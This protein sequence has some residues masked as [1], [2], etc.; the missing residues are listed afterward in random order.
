MKAPVCHASAVSATVVKAPVLSAYV[1]RVGTGTVPVSEIKPHP[2]LFDFWTFSKGNNADE[3]RD[4]IVGLNNHVLRAYNFLWSPLSGYGHPDYPGA[5]VLDGMD[6][7]L[8]L[9]DAYFPE[10]DYTVITKVLPFEGQEYNR[11][12]CIRS[13][14]NPRVDYN[15]LSYEFNNSQ[16][17][18]NYANGGFTGR[19]GGSI[20]GEADVLAVVRS[21]KRTYIYQNGMFINDYNHSQDVPNFEIYS[22]GNT[23]GW[24]REYF[25]GAFYYNAVYSG[26]LTTDELRTE[27]NESF[28]LYEKIIINR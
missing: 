24:V 27:M 11:I 4:R 13:L 1:G 12:F 20:P 3:S 7:H 23:P 19:L 21:G 5:I 6:D 22:L 18:F 17:S 25:H 14:K 8:E 26:A 15:Y 9:V 16:I 10:R 28:P 2:F